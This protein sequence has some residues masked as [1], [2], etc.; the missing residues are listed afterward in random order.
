MI[1]RNYQE[2]S[3]ANADARVETDNRRICTQ[4]LTSMCFHVQSEKEIIWN[5]DDFVPSEGTPLVVMGN[6]WNESKL[7]NDKGNVKLKDLKK[8][9][10]SG[11]SPLKQIMCP[12]TQDHSAM[13]GAEQENK[14]NTCPNVIK[15]IVV[16]GI[17]ISEFLLK[18]IAKHSYFVDCHFF[19]Y[20]ISSSWLRSFR[21]LEG[22]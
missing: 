17:I 18:K 15:T 22:K 1:K 11:K 12:T 19:S 14:L 21:F 3:D 6:S 20:W 16:S 9:N 13:G 7:L 4:A 2:K 8:F 5:N 10:L